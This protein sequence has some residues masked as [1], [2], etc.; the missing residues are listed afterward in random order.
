MNKSN[1]STDIA[2]VFAALCILLLCAAPAKAQ[3]GQKA[4]AQKSAA[5]G[6][7]VGSLY[8]VQGTVTIKGWERQL[9]ERDPAL[10][11]F[12]WSP[13]TAARPGRIYFR[14]PISVNGLKPYHN[15]KPRLISFEEA[16]AMRQRKATQAATQT[17]TYAAY[18]TSAPDYQAA[19][20]S[21][22]A[23]L[24]V[25]GRLISSK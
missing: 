8:C 22:P 14:Q 5:T 24:K 9:I 12:H 10:A 20:P 23:T 11:K 21:Y 6:K 25:Q 4:T 1:T 3:P 16:R 7:V 15:I 2:L 13:I 17:R 18:S 19:Q